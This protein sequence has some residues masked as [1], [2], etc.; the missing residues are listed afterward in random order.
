MHLRLWHVG[1]GFNCTA[2]ASDPS[3]LR[4]VCERMHPHLVATK[5]GKW[6]AGRIICIEMNS[7]PRLLSDR[8]PSRLQRMLEMKGG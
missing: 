1:R 2:A 4:F 5:N 6:A 3:N 7:L 8:D